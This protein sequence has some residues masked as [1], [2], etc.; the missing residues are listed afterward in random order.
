[1]K[2]TQTAY[3]TV[4][5]VE[6]KST[7]NGVWLKW[8]APD[9]Q[10]YTEAVSRTEDFESADYEPLTNRD[11][12]GWTLLDL[13][14]GKTYTYLNDVNNP[15]RTQPMAYQLYNPV[16]AGVPEEYLIDVPPHSGETLLVAW[17]T[18]G[19]NDNWLISPELSGAA[20]TVSFWARSFTIAYGEEF[21]V[22]YSLTGKWT[23]WST[24]LKAPMLMCLRIG[25]SSVSQYPRAPDISQCAIL[26]MTLMRFIWTISCLKRPGSFP[27]ISR[28]P[29]TTYTATMK[30]W[31]MSL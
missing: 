11:F 17:S 9:F 2:V 31:L 1:M 4:T 14:G 15:Y 27:L 13:D 10:E 6:G 8:T 5:G 30:R 25:P 7:L 24:I 22:Y 16:T 26:P 28:S 12:G 23:R 19:P 3:P 29:A 21:E 20:Q 18:N